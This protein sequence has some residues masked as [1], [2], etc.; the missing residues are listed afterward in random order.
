MLRSRLSEAGRDSTWLE[1]A[2]TIGKEIAVSNFGT[3]NN[4][5][6]I[7][8]HDVGHDVHI[9]LTEGYGF[10]SFATE[11]HGW[12]VIRHQ[13]KGVQE[14]SISGRPIVLKVRAQSDIHAS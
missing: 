13:R 3:S 14:I 12:A 8:L 6:C 10:A 11:E 4:I 7:V 2:W 1:Y 5:M 9:W